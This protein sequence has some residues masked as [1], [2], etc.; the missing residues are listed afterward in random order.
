MG[1]ITVKSAVIYARYSSH[2]QQEQSIEGQLRD[3]YAFAEREGYVVLHE[4]IDRAISG[5]T[6]DRP[7]FQQMI[8]HSNKGQ[9][10]AV[11][12][13]KLDRFAR[14]RFDSAHYKHVLKKHGVRVISATEH[15]SDDPE[16]IILEGLLESLAEYY[17][18]NLSKHVRRGQR[19]SVLNGTYTG[20]VP[21]FGFKVENKRLVADKEKAPIIQWVFEQYANGVPKKQIIDELNARGIRNYHGQPMSLS[22]L[23]HALRNPKYIGKYIFNG[24]E[25]AGG[26]EAL[27]DE[28]TFNKVQ[29][30]LDAVSRAPAAKKAHVDYLLQ[31]KGFCGMCGSRLVGE[32]GRGKMGV[33]YHYY[34]CASRKK[35]HT[36]K[37]RNERK[38]F[39]EWYI[40]EQTVAYVLT[41]SRMEYIANR[42][43]EQ[44]K[45]DFSSDRVKDMERGVAKL[46]KEM[47]KC[48]DDFLAT[49]SK[50]LKK[51]LDEKMDTLDAQKTDLELDLA[52]LRLV[53]NTQYTE[54]QII[55][56]LKTFCEGDP[57]EPEFQQRIIDVFINSVYIYDDKVVIYYNIKDGKQISYIE[58]CDD[59]EGLEEIDDNQSHCNKSNKVRISSLTPFRGF[60]NFVC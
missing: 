28:A 30:R 56:W 12:V 31:G 41:P 18:A 58:M 3:C 4:Y 7:S 53:S 24:E 26:C 54:E 25:V 60:A 21:P 17:S 16:G 48:F 37:K 55:M 11:I 44:C 27:I 52:R 9:F 45:K 50:Q 8:D 34:A 51:R 20:G 10:Q 57:I 40:V 5:R 36:C 42:V 39:L 38:E 15:I 13:W 29:K 19:E 59:M 14:N 46:E 33:V 2:S 6:D 22:S 49:E 43:V 32:S 35:H 47:Q 23:Q 1:A